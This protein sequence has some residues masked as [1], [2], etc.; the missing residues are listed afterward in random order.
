MDQQQIRDIAQFVAAQRAALMTEVKDQLSAY[1]IRASGELLPD[2]AIEHLAD[3]ERSTADRLRQRLEHLAAD[4]KPKAAFNALLREQAFTALNRLVALRMA[5]ARGV[6]LQAVSQGMESEGFVLYLQS[7]PQATG[8][9]FTWYREYLLTLFDE[10]SLELPGLFDRFRGEGLVFPRQNALLALVGAMNAAPLEAVWQQDETIGWI[11][12]YFNDPKERKKLREK[13]APT[14]SYELAV[15][16][17][18]FTPRYVVRFLVDNS[19][20]RLWSEMT[21][22][23]GALGEQC[24][25]LAMAAGEQ[26][27]AVAG[28]DPRSLAIIDPACGSMHFGLYTFDVLAEIYHDAARRGESHPW[29]AEFCQAYPDQQ[30]LDREI[31]RLICERNLYGIDIDR[32]AVQI[33]G[34][35]LWL[36]A[37]RWWHELGITAAERPAIRKFNLATAQPMPGEQ[38]FYNDFLKTLQPTSLQKVAAAVWDELKLAGEVGSLLDVERTIE[39][40]VALL[41]N[42]LARVPNA[43]KQQ[44]WLDT[45][46]QAEYST[47]RYGVDLSE[48][49]REDDWA[50]F[51]ERVFTALEEFAGSHRAGRTAYRRSLFADDTLT[52]F[53][54]I[55]VLRRDF[56]VV[57]MNPPF[58]ESA[59]GAKKYIARH[60]ARTKNDL[61]AAFVEGFLNR[62][63]PGGYLGA[64]TSR[65]GFFLSSFTKWR[66]EILLQ[67]SD[68][69]VMADLGFG[70]LDAMVETAAYVLRAD[71]VEKSLPTR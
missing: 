63:T 8:E 67:E 50:T 57:L 45:A 2:S 21:S 55:D 32:R 51:E 5:E 53:A 3:E 59:A 24:E 44:Y 47:R 31:P 58:G 49:T 28:K 26:L 15:R 16:N 54:F 19:L 6:I 35:T 7:V 43:E 71:G 68:P 52:G 11:Y 27:S 70:V 34:M 17:Q 10:L 13:G 36:R 22:D 48:I 18:F 66:E 65:T 64:I 14:D 39:S 60:Y 41:R 4:R 37:H 61:Y 30:T 33:A 20:G 40:E 62:L 38:Q 25:M 69:V 56:D 1:G 29:C 23:R 46:E 12:Q 9:R 42:A